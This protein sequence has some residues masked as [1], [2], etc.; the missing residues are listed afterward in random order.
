MLLAA[1]VSYGVSFALAIY[2]FINF[3]GESTPAPV[4]VILVIFAI[5]G[6]GAT[7]S[8]SSSY[9]T[10]GA[11]G[12]AFFWNMVFLFLRLVFSV[13]AGVFVAPYKLVKALNSMI[14]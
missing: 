4:W 11:N 10:G 8:S 13:I 1:V 3:N 2:A 9:F 5:F 6:F 7:R 14:S 12:E